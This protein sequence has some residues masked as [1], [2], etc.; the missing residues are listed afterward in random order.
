MDNRET[1]SNIN[2]LWKGQCNANKE[3][4]VATEQESLYIGM[5]I[6]VKGLVGITSVRFGHSCCCLLLRS[7]VLSSVM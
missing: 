4:L 5:N 6:I 2:H 7:Q 1:S 3:K